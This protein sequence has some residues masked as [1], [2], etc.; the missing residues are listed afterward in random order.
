MPLLPYD[1]EDALRRILRHHHAPV[2]RKL[3]DDLST[4]VDWIK[5]CEQAKIHHLARNH[6]QPRILGTVL[7]TMGIYGKEYVD[8]V[9]TT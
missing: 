9:P 3:V 2:D 1:E 5:E 8:K 6:P 4:F 7:S